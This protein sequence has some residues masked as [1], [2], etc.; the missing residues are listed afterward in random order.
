MSGYT[1]EQI[2]MLTDQANEDR[3][4]DVTME[5]LDEAEEERERRE[6]EMQEEMYWDEVYN[7]LGWQDYFLNGE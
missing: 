5:R 7:D 6:N 3:G 4:D 2:K 1:P